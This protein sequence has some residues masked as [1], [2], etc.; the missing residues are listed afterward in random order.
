VVQA[1]VPFYLFNGKIIK[2]KNININ[3]IKDEN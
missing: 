1:G 2:Y 3:H